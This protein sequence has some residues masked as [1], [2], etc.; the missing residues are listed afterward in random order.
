MKQIFLCL[1]LIFFLQRCG[2]EPDVF[3][4][5]EEIEHRIEWTWSDFFLIQNQLML[6]TPHTY[7]A[8]TENPAMLFYRCIRLQEHDIFVSERSR[9]HGAYVYDLMQF[10][11]GSGQLRFRHYRD[12]NYEYISEQD[13]TVPLTAEEMSAVIET[14]EA[15]DFANIPTWDPTE[16]D[17]FVFDSE[18]LY[19]LRAEGT[20]EHL[21]S[22]AKET[23]VPADGFP[24][25]RICEI[26]ENLIRE[27]ITVTSGRVFT[28]VPTE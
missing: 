26:I 18:L 23:D 15:E 2:A 21:I 4:S 10:G 28:E 12:E 22:M 24:I 25:F 11:D 27:K 14:L 8:V 20:N 17:G 1:G 5:P 16:P 19:I 6:E 3:P 13:E 9:L 7:T